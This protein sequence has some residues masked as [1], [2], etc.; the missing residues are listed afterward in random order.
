MR[1]KTSV[2]L[3]ISAQFSNEHQSKYNIVFYNC[4]VGLLFALLGLCENHA[5]HR[6]CALYVC[7]VVLERFADP[8]SC[9]YDLYHLTLFWASFNIFFIW[10]QNLFF[11]AFI[12]LLVM[13]HQ[14]IF[15]CVCLC[16]FVFVCVR[17]RVCACVFVLM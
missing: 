14:M 13:K 16:V 2:K 8:L 15:V 10:C 9:V 11:C 3:K 6:H 5:V 7:H 1:G 12:F 17:V 4:S